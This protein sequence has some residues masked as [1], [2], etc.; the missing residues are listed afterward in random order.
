MGLRDRRH[1]DDAVRP[2]RFQMREKMLD[3]G[4]DYWIE[5]GEGQRAYK[6]DGKA[7]RIR[8]TFIL[9]DVSGAEV[10]KIQERKITVRD[11][12]KIER[13][14]GGEATVR[15]ALVGFR[16]R[17]KIEVDGAPDLSAHGNILDHEYEIESDGDTIATV[18]KKWFRVRET[19]GIEIQPGHDEAL[20]LAIT[21]CVDAMSRG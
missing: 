21:V 10:A 11:T 6:V 2:R 18:S 19:Y 5:D 13:A 3:I 1:G 9:K 4:D 8:Q 17:F 15:K 14:A 7:V 16:D 20:I 12:M